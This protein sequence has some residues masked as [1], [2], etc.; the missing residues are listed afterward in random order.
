MIELKNIS[1]IYGSKTVLKDISLAIP[2]GQV[3]AILGPSG[4]GKSTL[5][6]CINFLEKPDSGEVWIEGEKIQPENL[7]LICQKIGM[8]FQLFHL[9]PHFS[10][11]K[12]VAYAPEKLLKLSPEAA[13]ARALKLLQQVGLESKADAYPNFLSGGQKQRAA[14]ARA[15]AM[16]PKAMLLDEPTS[17]LDPEVVQEVLEVIQKLIETGLTVVM[18]T[19]EM[20][21]AKQLADRILFLDEGEILE[22]APPQEFFQNPKTERARLFLSKVDPKC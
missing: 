17:A 14:I 2:K 18:V 8:V 13:E 12:N 4:S 3:V 6:R 10:V 5:L 21:F 16:E 11:L 9:F 1:K 20:N 19:H 15:L 7:A 22:D